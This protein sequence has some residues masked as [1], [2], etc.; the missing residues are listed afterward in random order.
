MIAEMMDDKPDDIATLRNMLA[1]A[2]ANENYTRARQ[3]MNLLES[4]EDEGEDAPS[5]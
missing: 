5:Y 2:M 1:R 4:I 3:F